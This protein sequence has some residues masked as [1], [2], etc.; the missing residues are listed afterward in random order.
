MSKRFCVN[1]WGFGTLSIFGALLVQL[2]FPRLNINVLSI[3]WQSQKNSFRMMSTH[4]K[5][6]CVYYF[7]P[8]SDKIGL[9]IQPIG[10][11]LFQ[12]NL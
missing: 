8:L 1:F 6:I 3:Y 5:K 11:C 7:K 10:L 12:K 4:M 2:F 9:M